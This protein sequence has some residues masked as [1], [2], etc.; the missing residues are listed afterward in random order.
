MGGGEIACESQAE[1]GVADDV[2]TAGVIDLRVEH[3]HRNVDRMQ[4]QQGVR[5]DR[6][7][8]L[9]GAYGVVDC[10][11]TVALRRD[12]FVRAEING[13]G[14]ADIAVFVRDGNLE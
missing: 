14:A 11:E 3:A 6:S 7:R 9:S 4:G 13:C 8:S 1:I 10:K 5:A 12:V 2:A